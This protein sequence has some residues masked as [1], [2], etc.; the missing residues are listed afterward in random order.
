VA[1]LLVE[2]NWSWHYFLRCQLVAGL[3][4]ASALAIT[5]DCQGICSYRVDII[6]IML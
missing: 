6:A 5:R 2:K 3:S 4:S 1:R